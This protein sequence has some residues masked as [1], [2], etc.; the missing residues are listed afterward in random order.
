MWLF[1]ATKLYGQERN[2]DYE[3]RTAFEEARN[4]STVTPCDRDLLRSPFGR[5]LY[6]VNLY[7]R[8]RWGEAACSAISDHFGLG[9]HRTYPKQPLF[10][11]TV[12]DRASATPDD[13]TEVDIPG[14]KTILRKGLTG[15]SYVGQIEP[16]L[17]TN[18]AQGTYF[19]GKRMVSWHFHGLVWG[20]TAA[21]L[22]SRFSALESAGTYRP[23]ADGLRGAH[24]RRIPKNQL[25]DKIRYMLKA[26]RKSYR[27]GKGKHEKITADGEVI[28]RFI[29]NK[30]DLRS[31]ERIVLF[32]LMKD[33][34]LDQ[35]VMGGGEGADILRRAKRRALR[36]L[37]KKHRSN[38]IPVNPI[39]FRRR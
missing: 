23:I 36:D 37:P 10:F 24:Y 9:S 29:Q 25:P 6:A 21:D 15:L 19:S 5:Y 17:Y 1:K 26:P 11:I 7:G 30:R 22:K 34:Y 27:I 32:N 20:A 18:V 33:M 38:P 4:R 31:G 39:S 16:G 13:A 28:S 35:L 12:V 14:F 2:T 3:L 8:L